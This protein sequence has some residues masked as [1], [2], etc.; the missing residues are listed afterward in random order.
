M[1]EEMPIIVHT[2]LRKQGQK[3]LELKY[4]KQ[5]P[6]VK[7]IPSYQV[8]SLVYVKNHD[9]TAKGENKYKGRMEIT[10][11]LSDNIVSLKDL[12]TGQPYLPNKVHMI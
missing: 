11:H 9:A 10:E 4:G 12:E 5:M 3:H 8:G 6:T 1:I 7:N 2:Q